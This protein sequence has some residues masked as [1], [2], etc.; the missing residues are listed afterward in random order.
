MPTRQR[1]RPSIDDSGSLLDD[2]FSMVTDEDIEAFMAEQE[3][4][5]E[6]S[7]RTG[8]LNLQ[9]GAGLAM[10]ALGTVYLLQQVGLLPFGLNLAQWVAVLP[11]LAGILIILTGFGVLSWR[12]GARK[13]KKARRKAARRRAAYRKTVGRAASSRSPSSGM[14]EAGRRAQSAFQKAESAMRS[15]SKT[16]EEAFSSR[17]ASAR[18]KSFSR[19]ASDRKIAGVAGGIAEYLGVD[20]TLIRIAFVIAT[21]LGSGIGLPLYVVLAFVIPNEE[22]GGEDEDAPIRVIRG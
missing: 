19:S 6:R 7:E 3:A 21:V 12:P 11:W 16:V 17:T 4:E 9:T 1:S 13:R 10:I 22:D 5:E 15:A 14:D 20:S 18:M 8:F 2:E